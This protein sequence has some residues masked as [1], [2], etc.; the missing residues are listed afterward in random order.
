MTTSAEQGP[1]TPDTAPPDARRVAD[2]VDIDLTTGNAFLSEVPHAAFDE[3]RRNGGIAWHDE[4]PV[5]GLMGDNPLL[6]F[7]D[8]PGFWAVTSYDLVVEVDRD[9][10]RFSSESGG[11][12]MP[13]MTED[14][15]AMFRQMLLNM[16]NPQHSRLRRIVQPVF[17]PKSTELLRKSIEDNATEIMTNLPNGEFDLVTSVSAEMPLRVLAD[18]FGMPREDRNL[19]FEWSNSL[20]GADNP[21]ASEH[22]ADSM[23]AIAGMMSYGQAMADDRRANP[24]DDIVS[25]IVTAEVEGER[26]SDVEFQMFWL[27]L[28]IAGNETTRNAV[29]GSVVAL[30]QQGLW[31]WLADHVDC[32]PTAVDELLRYVS[33]VQNFRR[34]ATRDL[35]LGDQH[36]RAGDKVVMWFGA[37]NRDPQ[38]FVDPHRLDLERNPNPQISFGN[39][40]HFCLGANLAR[41]EMTEM[42]RNLLHYTPDLKIGVPT[43]VASNFING[44]SLLPVIV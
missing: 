22:A 33:P 7:V 10:E 20:L 36:V 3:M 19:I 13:S 16:D 23:T 1:S 37:A 40:P 30:H 34:T 35:V 21:S 38:V 28:V 32:L 18:L 29:S 11:T 25:R 42:L 6:Q 9:L 31:S 17:T 4:A 5:A 27:L 39:G 14:S 26:L 41:L 12:F 8:A 43:R 24:R 44:I 15:L 2:I